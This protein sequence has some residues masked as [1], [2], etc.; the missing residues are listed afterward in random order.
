[1]IKFI[2]QTWKNTE[3]PEKWKQAQQSVIKMNTRYKYKL[4][5]DEDN[6]NFV[7]THFPFFL[8]TYDSFPY[9][10][11]RVDAVRYCILY[12]HGGIYLDLDY[13]ANKSF[14]ELDDVL[15]KPIGLVRSINTPNVSTNSIMISTVTKHPFWLE[16]IRQMMKPTP[17]FITGKHLTVMTSTGPIMVNRVRNKKKFKQEYQFLNIVQNCNVCNIEVCKPD[18]NF[19]LTPIKGSSWV[20]SDGKMMIWLFCNKKKIMKT[21]IFLAICGILLIMKKN[22]Y[23]SFKK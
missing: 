2:F 22:G 5:T 10:I 4:F 23:F 6:R 16:C 1:M 12:I 3:I 20:G 21:L 18:P 8:K 14:D 7:K 15:T 19:I 17:F 9:D 11:Q 13:F